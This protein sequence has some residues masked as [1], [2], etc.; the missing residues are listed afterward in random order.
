M[1]FQQSQTFKN[2]MDAYQ[3]ELF[4]STLYSI[5]A[6]RAELDGFIEI[7]GIFTTVSR[8]EKEHGRILLRRMNNGTIPT[9]EENL[10][11]SAGMELELSELYS[12]Y[13]DTA[14]QEGYTDISALFNGLRNIELNHNL[15]FESVHRNVVTGQVF[16]KPNITLWICMQCGNIMSGPCAPEICPVCQFPQGYYRVYTNPT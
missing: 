12:T 10:L 9:T 8:N 15:I 11:A 14:R 3:R 5:Y 1:D 4:L 16:C 2:V 7:S 13:A 6:D